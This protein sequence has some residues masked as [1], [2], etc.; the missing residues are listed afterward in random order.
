MSGHSK[1]ANIKR[2]KGA[3]DAKRSKIFS[4]LVKEISVAVKEGGAEEE[5]NPRLR[6]AI[7]NA[8]GENMPKE[9]I[10]RAIS[11]AS[12]DS[13]SFEP[14]NFEGYGP[15]G[16]AIF[17]ECLTDNNNRT[18]S[19]IR[20][21]FTKKGGSLDKKGSLEFI[22]DQKGIF[23][24]DKD[25]I[26]S[27]DFELEIIDAGAEDI[28]DADNFY[29]ITTAREDYGNMQKKLDEL[30]I[31]AKKSGLRRIPNH[32]KAVDMET[33]KKVLDMAETFE[34]ED[35]VQQVYHNL[36]MTEE[37]EQALNASEA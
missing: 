30:G 15:G 28:E 31:E 36:E 29:I 21:I 14:V 2:R 4:K 6:A 8:K 35:D 9:N 25:Q 24:V 23:E 34:D 18:V 16:V 10:K 13:T 37:L 3:Q 17:I 12:S 26:N 11:K 20:S 5:M 27:E 19:A 1:W 32:R 22:F 33:A 7:A